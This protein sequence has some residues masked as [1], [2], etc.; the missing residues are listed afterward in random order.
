MKLAIARG[1]FLVAALGVAS[2]AAAAWQE[3]TTQ[4]MVAAPGEGQ[5]QRPALGDRGQQLRPDQDL[6]LFLF[7]LSQSMG[8]SN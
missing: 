5:C 4:V 1:C 7:G 8:T 3:P 2:Y 6:L